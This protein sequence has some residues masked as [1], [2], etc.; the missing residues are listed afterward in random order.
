MDIQKWFR[1]KTAFSF[2]FVAIF[3][4]TEFVFY[5]YYRFYHFNNRKSKP[6]AVHGYQILGRVHGKSI[7]IHIIESFILVL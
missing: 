3:V 1:G 7:R 5:T 2:S 4:A 6:F